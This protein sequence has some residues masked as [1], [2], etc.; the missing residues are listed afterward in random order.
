[1]DSGLVAVGIAIDLIEFYVDGNEEPL[2][3]IAAEILGSSSAMESIVENSFRN[4]LI[5]EHL[6]RKDV[7]ENIGLYMCELYVFGEFSS[8]GCGH[9]EVKWPFFDKHK[10]LRFE[11]EFADW[12]IKGFTAPLG[13]VT[14]TIWD[15]RPN[16]VADEEPFGHSLISRLLDPIGT[17]I[18]EGI[19]PQ[20]VNLSPLNRESRAALTAFGYILNRTVS[21]SRDVEIPIDPM[22]GEPFTVTDRGGTI[23]IRSSYIKDGEPA[24]KYE[25]KKP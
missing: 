14:S 6:L 23:E 16:L 24:V 17:T 2:R 7:V 13:T 18:D 10:Y 20:I 19:V 5:V 22:T 11:Y 8:R 12:L 3:P 4:A 1:M 15:I 25:F 9:W 21:G